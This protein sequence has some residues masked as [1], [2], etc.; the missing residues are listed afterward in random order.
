MSEN[1]FGSRLEA[2]FLSVMK[3]LLLL[4]LTV[5]IGVALYAGV[6]AVMKLNV[7]EEPLA[8]GPKK[9]D[10]KLSADDFANS[11]DKKSKDKQVDDK[12][13]APDAE[14]DPAKTRRRYLEQATLL[15]SHL[16]MYRKN[17]GQSVNSGE[18]TQDERI[19]DLRATIEKVA[20]N[21]KR[22]EPYVTSMVD[23]VKVVSTDQAIVKA[24]KAGKLNTEEYEP[25]RFH[26]IKWGV[27]QTALEQFEKAESSRLDAHESRQARRLAEASTSMMTHI[28]IAGGA[29]IAFILVAMILI[30]AKIENHLRVLK[31][32]SV[33]K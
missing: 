25:L 12:S 24:V 13:A 16:D 2:L 1:S 17:T 3:A 8:A 11:A 33:V 23:W 26:L 31:I 4:A 6:V 22:G 18:G 19:E 30:L 20:N 5:S 7:A 32:E 9:P 28:T 14:P 15:R 10:F 29:L 21:P 27:Y